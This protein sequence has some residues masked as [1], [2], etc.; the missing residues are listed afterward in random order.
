MLKV[1]FLFLLASKILFSSDEES[2]KYFFNKEIFISR[3]LKLRKDC[4]IN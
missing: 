4:C 3:L 1:I 2:S